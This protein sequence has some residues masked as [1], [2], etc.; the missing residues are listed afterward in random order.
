MKSNKI[1]AEREVDM[2]K[3][4]DPTTEWLLTIQQALLELANSLCVCVD[5]TISLCPVVIESAIPNKEIFK[6]VLRYQEVK[7]GDDDEQKE[8]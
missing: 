1:V 2:S 4:V 6:I 8:R 5:Y 3:E 7:R